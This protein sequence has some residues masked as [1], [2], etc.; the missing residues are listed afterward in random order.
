M[1]N[2]KLILGEESMDLISIVVPMAITDNLPVGVSLPKKSG[3]VAHNFSSA[4]YGR[5]SEFHGSRTSTSD[6]LRDGLSLLFEFNKKEADCESAIKRRVKRAGS[7]VR[8]VFTSLFYRAMNIA[9]GKEAV[10]S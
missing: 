2:I 10:I 3:G 8:S 1:K 7:S 4:L 6:Y 5:K 9:F